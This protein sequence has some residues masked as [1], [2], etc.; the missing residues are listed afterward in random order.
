MKSIFVVVALLTSVTAYAATAW[1][2]FSSG[3]GTAFEERWVVTEAI[4]S[5]SSDETLAS[6]MHLGAALQEEGGLFVWV[7]HTSSEICNFS[8]W[9]LAVDKTV[10]SVNSDLGEDTKATALFPANDA[11]SVNLLELFREGERIA[12]RFHANC[13]NMFYSSYIGGAT[14]TYALDGSS[15]ALQFLEGDAPEVTGGGPRHSPAHNSAELAAY[16]SVIAR[17]IAQSWA[18]PASA[19]NDTE[20]VVRVR[21][22]RT[23]EVISADIISCN[24]DDAVRRSVEAAVMRASPLPEPSNPDLFQADLRIT[25]RPDR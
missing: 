12:V 24:G 18:V 3:D 19:T 1:E 25:L 21:Q 11:E 8:E 5:M 2:H 20:C 16:K 23:G 17:K 4:T 10:I 13:D 22:A 6:D 15:A 7:T 9:R 14:M